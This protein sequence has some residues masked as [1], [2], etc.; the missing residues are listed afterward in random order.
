MSDI[1]KQWSGEIIFDNY[2]LSK[3]KGMATLFKKEINVNIKNVFYG[4]KRRLLKVTIEQHDE[5]INMFWFMHQMIKV[6]RKLRFNVCKKCINKKEINILC[7][8][9]MTIKLMH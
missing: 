3:G 2:D 5:T 7:G 6:K 1:C 4:E 9:L 8:D